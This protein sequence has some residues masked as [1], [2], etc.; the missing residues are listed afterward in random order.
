[1]CIRDRLQEHLCLLLETK[2]QTEKR[3]KQTAIQ[4]D[5]STVRLFAGFYGISLVGAGAILADA[6]TIKRF[7]T[8]KKFTR[9]MRSAPRVDSSNKTTRIGSI[10]KAGRKTSFGYLVEG[11]LNIYGG[12]PHYSS[13]Y[14]DKSKGKSKCKV[15][16]AIV[17]KT[18][19]AIFYMWKNREEY[20]FKKDAP[21]LRKLKEIEK[22]KK[23]IQAS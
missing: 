4:Y 8:A 12:N 18:L 2:K 16:A 3:I 22:L 14:Y 23:N 19:V 1:M 7:K 21:T 20:R 17:R 6:G 15:R 11:L 10:D 13:F 5:E 9:Y